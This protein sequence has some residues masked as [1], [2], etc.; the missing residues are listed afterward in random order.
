MLLASKLYS[1]IDL[2]INVFISQEIF[3]TRENLRLLNTV[4]QQQGQSV[5]PLTNEDLINIVTNQQ[6]LKTIQD[7]ILFKMN[8]Q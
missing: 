1:S 6:V 2:A 8:K 5:P 7:T 4:L 3:S